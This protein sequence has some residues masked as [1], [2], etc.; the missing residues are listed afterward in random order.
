MGETSRLLETRVKKHLSRNLSTVHEHCQL[1]SHSVDSSKTKVLVT[2]SNTVKRHMRVAIEIRLRKCRTQYSLSTRT[3]EQV[4]Q[5]VNVFRDK[6]TCSK[7][8]TL[9]KKKLGN[10]FFT[11][12]HVNENLLACKRLYCKFSRVCLATKTAPNTLEGC[13]IALQC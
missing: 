9:V 7:A 10:F 11:H 12:T 2:E 3:D 5:C 8:S 13:I 4:L 1:T 6:C